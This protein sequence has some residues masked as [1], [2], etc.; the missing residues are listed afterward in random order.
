MM[1]GFV[2]N[3]TQLALIS[4]YMIVAVDM[5]GLS[6]V[7]P[8]MSMYA[9]YL[10]ATKAAMGMLFAGYSAGSFLSSLVIG[11]ISGR[12]ELHNEPDLCSELTVLKTFC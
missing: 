4:V 12:Y 10:G 8:V 7:I 11:K 3:Q 9:Q 2:F 5:F 1:Y 6:L